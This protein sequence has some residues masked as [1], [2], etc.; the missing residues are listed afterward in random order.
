MPLQTVTYDYDDQKNI[1]RET[2]NSNFVS[3][4]SIDIKVTY[5]KANLATGATFEYDSLNN[6]QDVTE[7]AEYDSAGYLIKTLSDVGQN[8]EINQE[9]TYSY[10]GVVPLKF[11]MPTFLNFGLSDDRTPTATSIL[12][13]VNARYTADMVEESYCNDS[14]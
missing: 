1:I 6:V 3:I 14:F 12:S 13:R 8:G 4:P 9:I 11:N 10:E 5:N 7:K 2:T